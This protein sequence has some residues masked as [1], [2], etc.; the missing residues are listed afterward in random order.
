M[1]VVGFLS[2]VEAQVLQQQHLPRLEL[3]RQLGGQVAHAI[4]REG[5]V[6]RLA[7]RVIQ[8]GAQAVDHRPEAVFGIRLPLGTSQV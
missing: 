7:Q 1:G 8:Q 3:A 2:G 6:D 4:G 5:D